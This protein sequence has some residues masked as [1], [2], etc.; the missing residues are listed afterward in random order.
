LDIP[1]VDYWAAQTLLNQVNIYIPIGKYLSAKD[2]TQAFINFSSKLNPEIARKILGIPD[3]YYSYTLENN[4][5][6]NWINRAIDNLGEKIVMTDYE[7][8]DFFQEGK[9]YLCNF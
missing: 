6:I 3:E 4:C 8:L 9:V 2:I 5:K 1:D 7:A